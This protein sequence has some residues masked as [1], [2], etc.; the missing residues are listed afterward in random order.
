MIGQS[1]WYTSTR[2]CVV[3]HS[4]HI[5][6]G[7]DSIFQKPQNSVVRSRKNKNWRP[8]FAMSESTLI[9]YKLVPNSQKKREQRKKQKESKVKEIG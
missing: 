5:R 6:A 1:G 8:F 2:T 4:T 3:V 9:V 7:H